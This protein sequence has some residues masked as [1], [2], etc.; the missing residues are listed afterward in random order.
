MDRLARLQRIMSA[1]G[2]AARRST[3]FRHGISRSEIEDAL[4]SGFLARPIR[5]WY[6]TRAADSD[7]L[8]AITAGARLGCVSALRRWG[9]WSGPANDL[10]LHCPPTASRLRLDKAQ[11]VLGM[12]PVLPHPSVPPRR[13]VELNEIWRCAAGVPVVHWLANTSKSS[14]LDWIVSPTDALTQAIH[15]QNEEHAVACIDS[16]LH[17][18]VVSAQE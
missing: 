5:G 2:Q 4:A 16:A 18:R 11:T 14:A 12:Q 3:L 13:A 10:H 9:V 6:V 7:Q 1:Q 17:H 15:C 8:R